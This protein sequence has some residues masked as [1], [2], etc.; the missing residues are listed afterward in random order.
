[1]DAG[2]L[3]K[4][5][6]VDDETANIIALTNILSPEYTVYAAKSGPSAVKVA[7]EQ[8]PDVILLDVL[9]PEMSGYETISILK[10]LDET[11]D[12]PII[13]VTGLGQEEYEERGLELG[14]SDYISKPFS[15]AIVKLRVRSQIK[16]VNQIKTINSISITDDLTGISNRRGF[17][18]HLYR[19]WYR[20]M[21]E[22]MPL[23][24][25]LIDADRFKT[26]NDTYG[27]QQ[28]D[29]ALQRI[30]GTIESSLKRSTDIAARWGGEE[31]IA[32]LPNTDYEE[33]MRVAGSIRA[34]TEL[35]AIPLMSG[36]STS[37]TVSIGV[38][39][40]VPTQTSSVE[41]FIE[42]ADKALYQ[43]KDAGRNRV[44]HVLS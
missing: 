12:I 40:I 2:N 20:A 29:V 8:A 38:N 23:T 42:D 39:T 36:E 6:V 4:V 10:G 24:I 21:R 28:G 35:T 7:I 43:A 11:R 1:M 33:A 17:D 3:N 9:M 5:L 32:L 31:F 18:V 22:A 19:E 44:S 25:L 41:G 14:A 13:F 16:I 27:H 34:N 15:S 30:A 26:Y 37:V